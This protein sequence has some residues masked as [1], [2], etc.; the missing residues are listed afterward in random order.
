VALYGPGA[1]EIKKSHHTQP[2]DDPYYVWSGQASGGW[3]VTLRHQKGSA[4][5]SGEAK[6][7]WRSR[8]SGP[9]QL[10]LVVKLSDGTWLI[11]EQSDGES[12]S[13]REHEFAIASQRWRKLDIVTIMEGAKVTTPDLSR[14]EEIGFTDLMAGGGSAACSRLDWIEVYGRLNP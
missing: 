12:Q 4:D 5:L 14:V 2:A 10:R 7:R 11:S 1:K 13:G 3:V 6:V 8:Q 9:R